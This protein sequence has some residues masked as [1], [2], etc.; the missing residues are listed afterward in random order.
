[1]PVLEAATSPQTA[2][3][4][5]QGDP[6]Y[7]VG[8][9]LSPTEVAQVEG[10]VAHI[11]AAVNRS[12]VD[13]AATVA[14]YVLE[15][16]FD[17]SY[18]AFADPS[19]T[20]LRSFTALCQREDLALSQ[21]SLYALVRVGH[22][23]DE[24]PPSLARALSIKHHR[25][26][27]PLADPAEKLALA[28]K[29]VAERWSAATLEAE[30]RATRGPQSGGRRP[31][32]PVLKEFRALRRALSDAATESATG[33]LDL[34]EAQKDELEATLGALEARIGEVRA[35]LPPSDRDDVPA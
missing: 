4:V 29:A 25:A 2:L 19:R 22:Q 11:N 10:A 28:H 7:V 3:A 1:M 5:G 6:L 15:T 21:P 8:D 13:L 27:L 24:L 12:G 16:F 33:L 20:K 35:A 34:S 30:V 32:P 18:E 9:E 23:L 14:S 31:L 26:L 17:G